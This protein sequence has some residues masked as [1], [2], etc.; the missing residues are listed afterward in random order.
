VTSSSST[1]EFSEASAA[2][3]PPSSEGRRRTRSKRRLGSKLTKVGITLCVGATIAAPLLAGAVHRPSLMATM[4]IVGIGVALLSLGSRLESGG[5]RIGPA[6]LLPLVFLLIPALQSIPLPMLLRKLLDP[7]GTALLRDNALV[8]PAV[9]PLSLDPSATRAHIGKAAAALAVFLVA[10]HLASGQTRRHLVMRGIGVAGIAAIVIG[11]GHRI[12]GTAK[13]YGTLES[14]HRTLLTG[15]FVNANH[16]AELLEIAAFTCLACAFQR[17]T[18]LNRAGWLVGMLLCAGGAAATLSRGAVLGMAAA[19]LLYAFLRYR[20]RDAVVST[21][22]RNVS[23]AWG[24]FLLGMVLVVAGAFGAG[25]LVDRFRSDAV[26]S[27]LR[28]QLWRDS[29]KVITAHP[30]GIGRGAFDRVFPVHRTLK[31]VFPLRFGFVEN[32]PLQLLL[33]GGW[34]FF[35][36]AL[37]AMLFVVWQIARHGRRDKTEAA[38]MAG[39]FAVVVHNFVDFGLETPGVLLPFMGIL[40]T[41]LGRS[42]SAQQLFWRRWPIVTACCAGLAVGMASV[43]HASY[44]DFD[45]MLKRS[46]SPVERKEILSRA[47]Q[48]HPLDYYYPL[49]YARLEPIRSPAG[50]SSPRFRALNRAVALCPICESVHIE[51]ARN[52]WALGKRGQALL[53]WRSAIQIQPKLFNEALNELFAAGAKPQELASIAAHDPVRMIEAATFLASISRVD[54]ATTVLD[55][56][57]VLGVPQGELLLTRAKLQL[58]SGKKDLAAATLA[59]ARTAGVHDVRVA[60]LDAQLR[61][62]REGAAGADQALTILDAAAAQSPFDV[63]V[64]KMRLDLITRFEKWKLA[65]RGLEGL[66]QALYYTHGSAIE[67]NIAAARIYAR[68]GRWTKALAEYRIALT[69]QGSNVGL[70][71]EY[72]RAA[73]TAGRHQTAR[74]AYQQAAQLSPKN[75]EVTQ[76][77]KALDERM[78][79]LRRGES[80]WTP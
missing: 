45:G 65:D 37:G 30:L 73:E 62:E 44:D 25:Q 55:Q 19:V 27:D 5:L 79:R 32:Q 70:W 18:A 9:W 2:A 71:L 50:G 60:M 46:T 48:A 36:L 80:E 41:I 26:G 10:Y 38:L 15:P 74:E 22:A 17:P 7:V 20:A 76:A 64:Q 39:L 4:T 13:I 63:R 69:N 11:I 77:A 33:D 21:Q 61:I 35:A 67:A 52:L 6:V 59:R 34:L 1:N 29:W 24:A 12:L 43:A 68:L 47:Q 8:T 49:L 51:V 57:E 16:T 54:E 42:L 23:L 40:G 78:M 31:T 58:Q 14:T 3:R 72:G 53:E 28:F 56:A 75:A 66:K